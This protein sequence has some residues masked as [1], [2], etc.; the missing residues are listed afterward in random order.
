MN[1]NIQKAQQTPSQVK[2]DGYA[3]I[4][5]VKQPKTPENLKKVAR[6]KVHA[7]HMDYIVTL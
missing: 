6:M 2:P 3:N 5:I 7:T 1:K 4:L